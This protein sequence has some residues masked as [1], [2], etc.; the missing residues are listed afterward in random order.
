[1]AALRARPAIWSSAT[2]GILVHACLLVA[3]LAA[4]PTASLSAPPPTDVLLLPDVPLPA[5]HPPKDNPAARRAISRL[6]Q[7]GREDADSAPDDRVLPEEFK[8]LLRSTPS[9]LDGSTLDPKRQPQLP[10]TNRSRDAADT[11]AA[12]RSRRA[13][14]MLLKSA[15]LLDKIEPKSENR[16]YLIHQMRSEAVRLLQQS[17]VSMQGNAPRSPGEASLPPDE[18]SP[19]SRSD[20]PHPPPQQTP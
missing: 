7:G 8:E 11:P 19:P 6:L 15:R 4:T 10:S 17:A 14:E 1:M 13:A 9:V 16:T 5:D 20:T 2:G 12:R 18:T 3:S